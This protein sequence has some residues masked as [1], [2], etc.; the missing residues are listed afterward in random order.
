M[1]KGKQQTGECELEAGQAVW[2]AGT[3]GRVF[4]GTYLDVLGELDAVALEELLALAGVGQGHD[5]VSGA[6]VHEQR[7]VGLVSEVPIGSDGRGLR[8]RQKRG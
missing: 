6:V 1:R 3:K 7:D 8:V 2:D 4:L 5:G